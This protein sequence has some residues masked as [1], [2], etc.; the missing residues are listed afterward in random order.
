MS[1]REVTH[2][3]SETLQRSTIKEEMSLAPF[4]STKEDL[5]SL[6]AKKVTLR[7]GP[8]FLKATGRPLKDLTEG[9]RVA[10]RQTF[11]SFTKG[12]ILTLDY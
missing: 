6:T 2:G 10:D 5:A 9:I 8:G 3:C 7:A 4:P 12:R 11:I 1:G